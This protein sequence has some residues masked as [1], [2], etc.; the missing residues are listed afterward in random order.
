MTMIRK[1][2]SVKFRDKLLEDAKWYL[3]EA[4]KS[5]KWYR[6][7]LTRKK[8]QKRT[9]DWIRLAEWAISLAEKTNRIV[10]QEKE[11]KIKRKKEKKID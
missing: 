10:E 11:L 1:F 2:N 4:R 5:K 3:R 6:F 8:I 9:N 7:G